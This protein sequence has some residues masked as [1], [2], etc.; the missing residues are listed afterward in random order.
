MRSREMEWSA[1]DQPGGDISTKLSNPCFTVEYGR[2]L[3]LILQT[4]PT[5]STAPRT[6]II[7][8]NGWLWMARFA[9]PVIAVLVLVAVR[10]SCSSLHLRPDLADLSSSDWMWHW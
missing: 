10:W 6:A 8:N 4:R 7:T 5:A 3:W 9:A 1:G 2:W